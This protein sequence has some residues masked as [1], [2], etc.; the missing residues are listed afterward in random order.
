MLKS[1]RCKIIFN[2]LFVFIHF[3]DLLMWLSF[4]LSPLIDLL[5]NNWMRITM[6]K[7]SSAIFIF[8]PCFFFF[9]CL[10]LLEHKLVNFI[11]MPPLMLY[12]L[13]FFMRP[14]VLPFL[15]KNSTLFHFL[16]FFLFSFFLLSSYMKTNFSLIFFDNFFSH[17]SF[18][19]KSLFPI[20]ML[21]LK[22]TILFELL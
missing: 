10:I 6:P 7:I 12:K 18:F 21:W 16:L 11:I 20:L 2:M 17:F 15:L 13:G 8:Y 5:L 4:F 9:S 14:I 19:F 3:S 1:S 22:F